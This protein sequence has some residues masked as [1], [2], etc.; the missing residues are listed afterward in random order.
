L[1]GLLHPTSGRV[2]VLGAT[3]HHRKA[4]FLR[5]LTFVMGSRNHLQWDLPAIDTF[6]VNQAIY[7]IPPA[8][9]RQALDELVELLDLGGLL[10]RP[11]RKLSLGQRMRCELAGALLHRPNVVFLDEPTIGLDVPTQLAIRRFLLHY[12]ARHQATVIL[13]SH[14]MADVAALATRVLIIANGQM[15]FDGALQTLIRRN[16]TTRTIRLTL[17]RP[18]SPS[19]IAE[20]GDVQ[21]VAGHVVTVRTERERAKECTLQALRLLPVVDLSIDEPSAEEILRSILT[22]PEGSVR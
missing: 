16:A 9:F 1:S 19:D 15:E 22:D 12:Q 14:Q 10:Q 4:A 3:P 21:S 7:T 11:V 6:Q 18:A 2:T 5:E 20:L 13:T 17:E 8:R